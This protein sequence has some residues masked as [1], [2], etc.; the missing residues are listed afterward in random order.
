MEA[1]VALIAA[2]SSSA[3]LGLGKYPEFIGMVI[4]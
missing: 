3:L 4:N 2:F 1:Q